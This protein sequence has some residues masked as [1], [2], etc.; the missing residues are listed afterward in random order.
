MD[1]L[2]KDPCCMLGIAGVG[3]VALLAAGAALVDGAQRLAGRL[4]ES[5]ALRRACTGAPLKD[6]AP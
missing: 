6:G 5:R 2:L 3:F 4:R 1:A